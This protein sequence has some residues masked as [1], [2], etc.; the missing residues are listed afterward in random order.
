MTIAGLRCDTY[1]GVAKC[2]MLCRVSLVFADIRGCVE[3]PSITYMEDRAVC[4]LDPMH[5]G[6]HR[7]CALHNAVLCFSVIWRTI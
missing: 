5:I 7:G 1:G 3:P 2:T 6:T 4:I